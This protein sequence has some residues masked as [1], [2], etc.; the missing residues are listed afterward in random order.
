MTTRLHSISALASQKDAYDVVLNVDGKMES[1]ICRIVVQ[2]GIRMIDPTPNL[3]FGLPF[4]PR[5][6]GAAV[7]AF[8]DAATAATEAEDK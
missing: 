8:H 2:S 5:I 3:M 4:D 6:L 7:V 1:M